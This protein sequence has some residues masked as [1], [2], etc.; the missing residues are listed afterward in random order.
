[1]RRHLAWI[2][3]ALLLVGLLG[4]RGTAQEA[5]PTSV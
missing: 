5:V 4:L 1:M 3:P 2:L